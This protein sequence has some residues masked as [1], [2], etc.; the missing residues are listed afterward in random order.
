MR[1]ALPGGTAVARGC[2]EQLHKYFRPLEV[3][4]VQIALVGP[5]AVIDGDDKI[6]AD[7][8]AGIG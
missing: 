3:A 7:P 5:G 8:V 1:S 2:Q 6:I 4:N